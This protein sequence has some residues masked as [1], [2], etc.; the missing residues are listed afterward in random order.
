M[1]HEHFVVEIAGE[2]VENLY[3]ALIS[4]E[5]ELDDE[6]AALFRLD[7]AIYLKEDGSWTF[8]DDSP[9]RVW[10][11][12]TISAGFVEREEL[13]DGYITHV[14]PHFDPD[15]ARC[16]LEI[17]GMDKSVLMDREEKLKDWP[18]KKDSDIAT[19]L[20]GLYGL[21]PEVEDTPIVHDA[22]VSTIIQR[23]T[24][25]QFLRRLALRNGCE[26]YVEGSTGYFRQP[27]LEAEPQP[28][29][30][31]H[32]GKDTTLLRFDLEVNALTPTSVALFQ[33][34]RSNKDVLVAQAQSSQ[35]RALGKTAS[36]A[37]PP[38]GIQTGLIYPSRS[39][40][41]G[42]PELTLLGQSLYHRSEWFVTGRGEIAANQYGHVLK[43]RRTVTLKGIGETYSGVYYVTHVTHTFTPAGYNQSFRVKRNALLPSGSEDFA[44]ASEQEG[45]LF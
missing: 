12:V 2:E 7:I 1:S 37:L 3:D 36:T 29:L 41:T 34:D 30:A 39:A 4:L 38:P 15:A 8:L 25:I 31:A 22:A 23:E 24:D 28:P 33:V 45:G 26:C 5:V 44:S 14:K 20:F 19:E 18:D 16:A 10:Q 43:P 6:L 27:R 40:T 13:L 9:F 42:S 21:T 35:Q 32:F 17:W 11:P